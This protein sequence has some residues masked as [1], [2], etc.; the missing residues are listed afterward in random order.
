MARL[1]YSCRFDVVAANGITSVLATYKDWIVGHYRT[2]R[3]LPDFEFHPEL[4]D[5]PEGLPSGHSLIS[6]IYEND[7]ERVVRIGWSFPDDT[8]AGLRWAN[9]VRVGQFG[10]RCGVE[11]LISIESVEYSVAPAR[12]LF[13][14]PRAIRDICISV[15]AYIGEMQVR[16]EPYVLKQDGLGDLFELLTSDLRKL[17]VV[18]LSPYARG[19]PNQIDPTNL[20]RN[21]AGVAVV[22]RV[23]NPE[24]TW[25]FADE[26]GRQLSCFNGAARIY[27]PGFSNASDPRIHRLFFGSWIEQVG[28]VVAARTIE[29]A[30]FAVAAFRYVPDKRIADVIRRAEAAERLKV[31]QQKRAT[32]DE[33]WEDYEHTVDKLGNAEEQIAALKAEN[34]NLRA[35][36]EV[37]FTAGPESSDEIAQTKSNEELSFSSVAEAVKAAALRCKNLEILEPPR[38]CRRLQL[39]RRWSHDKQDNEQVF[40]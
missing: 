1:V 24:L 13:G 5:A 2:R 28:P 32:G 40:S 15:P 29:R 7:S 37:F 23:E 12:L 11:H 27:W 6:S 21:L 25:D 10:D 22:V 38:V 17:P 19:E 30:I 20:A 31:L 8:D 16:A 4:A 9:E 34:A 3:E 26:V 39:L 18:L 36:Q 35:N 14:S 33:F